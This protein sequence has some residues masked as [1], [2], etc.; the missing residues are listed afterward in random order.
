MADGKAGVIGLVG[1][2]ERVGIDE[3]SLPRVLVARG[4]TDEVLG[5]L[6]R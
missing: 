4:G 3:L 2:I 6:A 1:R 5:L